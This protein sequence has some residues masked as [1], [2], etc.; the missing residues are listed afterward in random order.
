MHIITLYVYIYDLIICTY[1]LYIIFY[2]QY[3]LHVRLPYVYIW[4]RFLLTVDPALEIYQCSLR[5]IP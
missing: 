1:A 5:M 2:F 4:T 3:S